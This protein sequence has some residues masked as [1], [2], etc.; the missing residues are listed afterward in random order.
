MSLQFRTLLLNE[1][2]EKLHELTL[3]TTK[4]FPISKVLTPIPGDKGYFSIFYAPREGVYDNNSIPEVQIVIAK[5]EEGKY[6]MGFTINDAETQ[7]FEAPIEYYL[8][9]IKTLTL[10]LTRFIE[11]YNPD[12]IRVKG[13]DKED[14][15]KPGQKDR[16]YFSFLQ[17]EGPKLGYRVAR[18]G[19]GYIIMIKNK[20]N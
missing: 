15:Y 4:P 2:L 9:I 20:T 14:V 19:D 8:R 17:Q 7:A 11:K 13:V 10:I 18:D 6:E 12:S 5:S 3:G 16:I 1:E